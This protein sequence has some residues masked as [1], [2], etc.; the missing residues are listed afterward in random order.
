PASAPLLTPH[1][2]RSVTL[3][4]SPRLVD[5][6]WPGAEGAGPRSPNG[7]KA[8]TTRPAPTRQSLS[9]GRTPPAPATT[10]SAWPESWRHIPALPGS[11]ATTVAVSPERAR[12]ALA[13]V[14]SSLPG[15]LDGYEGSA[16]TSTASRGEAAAAGSPRAGTPG[17]SGPEAS[18]SGTPGG[19]GAVA[20][21]VPADEGADV[22]GERRPTPAALEACWPASAAWAETPPT[23]LGAP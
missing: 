4:T 20:P 13:M 10:T 21:A 16:E 14:A 8:T 7:S 17:S 22:A 18:S 3:S 15:A 5:T 12:K 2:P 19:A 6:T 11:S 1:A 9:A 23:R